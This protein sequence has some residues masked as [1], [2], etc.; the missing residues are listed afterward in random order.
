MSRDLSP[1]PYKAKIAG[2]FLFTTGVILGILFAYFNLVINLPVFAIFSSFLENRY[3]TVFTTNFTD[4]LVLISLIGGLFLI[5]FSKCRKEEESD[6]IKTIYETL[7]AKAIFKAL[8]YNTLIQLLSIVFIFGQGFFWV[9][10]I[11]LIS[12]FILY[13]LFF[14]IMKRKILK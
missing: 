12:V 7:K 13:L 8:Y 4:E 3:F 11:N 1:F 2:W 14:E 6:E 5:L 10:V 9:L